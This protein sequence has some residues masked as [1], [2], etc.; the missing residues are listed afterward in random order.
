MIN[1]NRNDANERK[2]KRQAPQCNQAHVSEVPL[3]KCT[4]IKA[5]RDM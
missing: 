2:W 3:I 1:G 4:N 5:E